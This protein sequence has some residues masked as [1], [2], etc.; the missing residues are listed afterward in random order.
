L[1]GRGKFKNRPTGGNTD[2]RPA[3][4]EEIFTTR[5]RNRKICPQLSWEKN[6]NSLPNRQIPGW[7]S[8]GGIVA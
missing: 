2:L 6:V 3:G 8:G 1:G 7:I 4:G 5:Q